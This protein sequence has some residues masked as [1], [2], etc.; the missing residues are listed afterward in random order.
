MPKETVHWGKKYKLVKTEA[1]ESTSEW[2]EKYPW[3]GSYQQDDQGNTLPLPPNTEAARYP[4][5]EVVWT[6]P[7]ERSPVAY[8]EDPEGFVQIGMRLDMVDMRHAMRYD[9]LDDPDLTAKT[10]FTGSLTRHQINQM[11]R[12]LKRARDAAFGTDE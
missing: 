5:L 4:S 1:T 3:D 11:I 2:Y 7:E 10:F 8:D 6:R 12:V 9:N